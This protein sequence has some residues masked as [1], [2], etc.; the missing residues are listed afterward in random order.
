QRLADP[1]P[2]PPL[3]AAAEQVGGHG[4]QGGVGVEQAGPARDDAVGGG[5]G[6]V[7]EGHVEAVA[8]VDKPG[9]GV[10]GGGVHADLP[11]PVHGHEPEGGVDGLVDHLQIQAV[12][13]GGG[14]PV[15]D[16]GPRE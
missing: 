2:A 9:H 1:D 15:A 4:G 11:V 16:R 5:G 6:V 7:G 13:V 8:Q 10:L 3:A 14:A 12:G